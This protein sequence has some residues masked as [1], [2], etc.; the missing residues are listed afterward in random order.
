M[1]RMTHVFLFTLPSLFFGGE[2]SP[3]LLFPFPARL[4]V[5]CVSLPYP[6][7]PPSG[8]P[9]LVADCLHILRCFGTKDPLTDLTTFKKIHGIDGYGS[10]LT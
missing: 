5:V 6:L 3:L 1:L 2:S 7:S 8:E 4:T 10:S 9:P